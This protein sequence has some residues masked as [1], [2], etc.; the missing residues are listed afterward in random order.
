MVLLSGLATGLNRYALLRPVG[1]DHTYCT[2]P[3][4]VNCTEPPVGIVSS[5]PAFA[6]G[7][8][9]IVTVTWSLIGG[10]LAVSVTTRV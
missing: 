6:V 10:Q 1:G 5:G 2:P 7:S 8:G 9:L 4:P 3:V